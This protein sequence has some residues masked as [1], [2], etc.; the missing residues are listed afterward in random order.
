MTVEYIG[1]RYVPKF[2]DPVEW[3]NTRSYEALMIVTNQ[4]NSYT[5]KQ[6]VPAG[7]DIAD[8]SYWANT[9]NYDAQIEQYRQDVQK[10]DGRMS[11]IESNAVFK[12][13]V[14]TKDE[15]DDSLSLKLNLN[16]YTRSNDIN[17]V[18]KGVDNTG[19]SPASGKLQ[20]IIDNIVSVGKAPNEYCLYIPQ[21]VY[22]FNSTVT[23]PPT[24]FNIH[25]LAS[26]AAIFRV[27]LNVTLD[28]MFVYSASDSLRQYNVFSGGILEGRG[29]TS[30]CLTLKS[31]FNI[32]VHNTT[33]SKA[34]D[35]ML[36]ASQGSCS[37]LSG[38]NIWGGDWNAGTDNNL[39]NTG[40][41]LAHDTQLTNCRIMHCANGISPEG[42]STISNL[43]MYAGNNQENR[44]TNGFYFEHSN[45]E[46]NMS[47]VF[48]DS[49]QHYFEAASTGKTNIRLTGSGL[50]CY[51][52]PN[53]VPS[54]PLTI[55]NMADRYTVDNIVSKH[56]SM[57]HSYR[58]SSGAGL[59]TPFELGATEYSKD[60][61]I[62]NDNVLVSN[63]KYTSRG[64]PVVDAKI[65][66][67][68]I[69][70]LRIGYIESFLGWEFNKVSIY[71]DRM[72]SITDLY[73]SW[74]LASRV[75]Y[76][77]TS[78]DTI[79]IRVWIDKK[80]DSNGRKY[81]YIS[82]KALGIDG[83]VRCAVTTGYA[84]LHFI[85]NDTTQYPIDTSDTSPY[86]EITE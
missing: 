66:V 71:G 85:N 72:Q 20:E 5:S 41:R 22:I 26:P 15:I 14:Y 86:I 79:K 24:D 21:G 60:T 70:M 13:K 74:S 73:I 65:G 28:S 23:V 57:P 51:A 10:F 82:T 44:I 59:I 18:E 81:I 3:D 12:D 7:I 76:T 69:Y 77:Y 42:Y 43:Y 32:K 16:D 68:D 61:I 56:I 4:G 30:K 19:A 78:N 40:I 63:N 54:A 75:V 80:T 58:Y 2:A 25:I 17:V 67:K 31:N 8:T 34:V 1:D 27:D 6:A 37:V 50:F 83:G 53:E 49:F 39:T 47:S 11:S 62:D 84:G 64:F 29:K 52:N 46:L 48:L 55:F 36:D 45:V 35:C 9:G 38:L 33:L